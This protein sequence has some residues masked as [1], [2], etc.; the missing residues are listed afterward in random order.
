MKLIKHL[1]YLLDLALADYFLFPMTKRELAGI[2]LTYKMFK[3][4][5]E[6][7]ERTMAAATIT[8]EFRGN[9]STMKMYHNR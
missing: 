6:A 2:A 1:P 4:E 5:W 9:I 7:A 3:K 8:K